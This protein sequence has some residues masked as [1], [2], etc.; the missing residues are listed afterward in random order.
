MISVTILIEWSK[1]KDTLILNGYFLKVDQLKWLDK[2]L[3]EKM[4]VVPK[5][6]KLFAIRDLGIVLQTCWDFD[7][8]KF[9][10]DIVCL[11]TV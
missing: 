3:E 1:D 5:M 2:Y 7:E 8:E 10:K 9:R 11:E 4:E 6:E